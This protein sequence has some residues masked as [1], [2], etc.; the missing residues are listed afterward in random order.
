MYIAE[1]SHPYRR[2]SKLKY[3]TTL[4]FV[5]NALKYFIDILDAPILFLKSAEMPL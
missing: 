1:V 5:Q 3:S 2:C 4:V